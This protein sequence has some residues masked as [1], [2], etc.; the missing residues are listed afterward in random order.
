MS[1]GGRKSSADL[2]VISNNGIEVIDRPAPPMELQSD[3]AKTEWVEIVNRLPADWFPRETHSLLKQHCRH[4]DAAD[5]IAQLIKSMED[6]G[7]DFN[8]DDYDKLLKMQERE[9]RTISSLDTRMRL[10]QQGRYTT[11]K[12]GTGSANSSNKKAPWSK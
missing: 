9:S 11:Q 4:V 8:L 5:K 12:A 1:K 7:C 3:A 6:G 10:T 2:S